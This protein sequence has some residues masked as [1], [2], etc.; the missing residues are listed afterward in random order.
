MSA[1]DYIFSKAA[2]CQKV[3]QKFLLR[4]LSLDYLSIA[5]YFRFYCNISLLYLWSKQYYSKK[6][7][8]KESLKR[9]V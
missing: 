3:L 2:D 5:L 9:T 4:I 6:K 1:Y 8:Q 7:Q